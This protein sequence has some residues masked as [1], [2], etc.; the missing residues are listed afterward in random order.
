MPTCPSL[1]LAW[2]FKSFIA[3]QV[4]A[5]FTGSHRIIAASI[6][7]EGAVQDKLML[8]QA[9]LHL[10]I[11]ER[12]V[13]QT[14]GGGGV[15]SQDGCNTYTRSPTLRYYV[16]FDAATRT[17]ERVLAPYPGVRYHLQCVV[18][19]APTLQCFLSAL[20]S[21]LHSDSDRQAIHLVRLATRLIGS[22]AATHL[23][24]H[25]PTASSII[26]SIACCAREQQSVAL[27][28]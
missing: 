4:L 13:E 18:S 10:A 22:L 3:Q 7:Y 27:E 16:L 21:R 20:P 8:R 5:F 19:P 2:T 14:W 25:S 24:G 28:F 6:F 1:F 9:G 23:R 11:P 15:E 26:S 17:T 12:C